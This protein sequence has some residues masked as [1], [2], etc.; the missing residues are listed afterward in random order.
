M[1]IY[2]YIDAAEIYTKRFVFSANFLWTILNNSIFLYLLLTE[3]H[4]SLLAIVNSK[5]SK[6]KTRKL[7]K[8][9]QAK[10][11]QCI[12]IRGIQHRQ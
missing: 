4:L 6:G 9:P 11:F 2:I 12:Q 3:S 10:A 1:N 5:Y 8:S 7:Y